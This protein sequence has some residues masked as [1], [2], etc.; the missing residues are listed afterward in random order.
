MLIQGC[1]HS[2]IWKLIN[3]IFPLETRNPS[4]LHKL[5]SL[6][7][8]W[9]KIRKTKDPYLSSAGLQTAMG[10]LKSG[11]LVLF[12]QHLWNASTPNDYSWEPE[13][14]TYCFISSKF[15]IEEELLKI[16]WLALKLQLCKVGGWKRSDAG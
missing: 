12:F 16:A 3:I 13:T 1:L 11:S 6:W 10:C 4:A 5:F 14:L 15:Y 8:L 7:K 2:N 9:L